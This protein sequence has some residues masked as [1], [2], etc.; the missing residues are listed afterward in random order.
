MKR[1][2][3]DVEEISSKLVVWSPFSPDPSLR[4]IATGVVAEEGVNVHEYESI[5]HK[6]MHKMI[7]QLAFTFTFRR[8]DKAITLGQTSAIRVAPDRTIDSAL[9]F[10]RFLVVSQTGE[11]ALEEVMHYELSPFPPALFEARDIFRKADKPQ[12]AHTICDHASDAILQS[13]PETE[14]H[15]LDGGSLLHQVPWK[16][17]QNDGEIA[18]SYADFTVRHYGSA[19]TVVFDGY[20][21]GPSI[22]DNTH[23]RRGHNSHPIVHF[24]ADT[25]FSGKKEKF[26]SRDFNKQTLIKM[27]IAELRRS[28]CDVVNAPGD[29]DVDIVKA[30]VRASLVHTTTLIGEDTDLLVLLLYYAQRDSKDLY[31]RSGKAKADGS[32]KVYDIK[33]LQ[34]ILGHDVCSQL[35]FIHAMTGCDTTSR[36]FSVGKKAAFQKL[37]KGDSVLQLCAGAFTIPNQTAD[38]IDDLGCQAMVILFGSK[39]TDSL[40]TTRFN[41]FS[42][43]VVSASSFVTPERLPPTESATRLHCRR[44]YY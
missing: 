28:G 32:F 14:C 21:E 27:I 30:A 8:K 42:K 13:V 17:G 7:G 44:V 10:Q 16:R 18:Q 24:T 5:G 23:Q 15:V 11:L 38:V 4:N 29:A 37:V 22:K 2:N 1:D 34:E 40:A 43:K 25:E 41:T 9:L 20:E 6:I 19:T 12:L 36:I 33:H 35:M 39:S 3:A 31:Y 26:L